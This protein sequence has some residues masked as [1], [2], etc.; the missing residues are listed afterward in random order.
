MHFGGNSFS[1][2][3]VHQEASVA[4][5]NLLVWLGLRQVGWLM[6]VRFLRCK[7]R[8]SIATIVCL[9]NQVGTRRRRMRRRLGIVHSAVP[10][11][12]F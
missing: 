9:Q 2:I 4:L 5:T 11:V 10:A 1:I 7:F 8:V 12:I 3:K 6:V